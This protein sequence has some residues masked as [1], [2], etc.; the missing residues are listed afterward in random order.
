MTA[1][2]AYD[3]IHL[4]RINKVQIKPLEYQT[5]AFSYISERVTS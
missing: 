1:R 4:D 5:L 3:Q 2:I